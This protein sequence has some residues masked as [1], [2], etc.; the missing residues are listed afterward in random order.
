MTKIDCCYEEDGEVKHFIF[1]SDVDCGDEGFIHHIT[2]IIE[3]HL[4]ANAEI[5]YTEWD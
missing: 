5:K 1:D 3:D 4:G 2:L